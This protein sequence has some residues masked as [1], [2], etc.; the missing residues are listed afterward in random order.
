[1]L[2]TLVLSPLDG[3]ELRL[4]GVVHDTK[5]LRLEMRWTHERV[6]FTNWSAYPY[7]KLLPNHAVTIK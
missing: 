3:P 6:L 5:V 1:M 2:P 7:Y 4:P